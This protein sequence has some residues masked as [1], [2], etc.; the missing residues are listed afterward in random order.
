MPE[1]PS[2]SSSKD[3]Q[4]G[5]LR[6]YALS[7][8]ARFPVSKSRMRIVLLRRAQAKEQN[9]S[10]QGLAELLAELEE[11]GYLN[12]EKFALGRVRGLLR[13]GASFYEIRG[14]LARDGVHSAQIQETLSHI[15]HA[16]GK[17]EL[18]LLQAL[19]VARK[20][21]LGPF[22]GPFRGPSRSAFD[23]NE[24]PEKEQRAKR[25]KKDL[26]ALARKGFSMSTLQRLFTA[27]ED[28]L[29]QWQEQAKEE[30]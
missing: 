11:L 16:G 30:D 14:K 8:L 18:E 26:L 10:E 1:P 28:E 2:T 5:A 17:Q 4:E 25:D 23:N 9:L 21:R 19:K 27:S 15:Q 20:R 7:Y 13:R 12:D 6:D 24:H 29:L 22:R 3:Q